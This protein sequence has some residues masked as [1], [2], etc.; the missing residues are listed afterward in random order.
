MPATVGAVNINTVRESGVFT[1]GNSLVIN[2]KRNEKFY[3]GSGF[4]NTGS[5]VSTHTDF[6]FTHTYDSDSEDNSNIDNN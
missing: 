6:S 1:I 3:A 2:P 5:T 4:G